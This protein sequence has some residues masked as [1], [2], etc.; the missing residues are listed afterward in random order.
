MLI[1]QQGLNTLVEGNSVSHELFIWCMVL[2]LKGCTSVILVL[3]WKKCE[4]N[5]SAY[6]QVVHHE[7]AHTFPF[8][9]F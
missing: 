9:E 8:Q 2:S 7:W 5:N 1:I 4:C 3:K 6:F